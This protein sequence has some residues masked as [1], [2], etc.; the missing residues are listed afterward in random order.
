[1][2]GQS[3]EPAGQFYAGGY[4]PPTR[5]APAVN[6]WRRPFS[7]LAMAVIRCYQRTLS[8]LWP[9]VCRYHPSCSNYMLHAIARRGLLVGGALGVWRILRCN[10]F[11]KGG[12]DPPPGYEDPG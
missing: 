5:P 1:M 12:Y 3:D 4:W 11:A 10:P 8:R 9:N 7:W 6:P 2:D